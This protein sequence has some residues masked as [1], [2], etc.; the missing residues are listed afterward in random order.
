MNSSNNKQNKN[1]INYINENFLGNIFL[2]QGHLSS[3]IKPKNNEL[4]IISSFLKEEINQIFYEKNKVDIKTF[5]EKNIEY[6]G[7]KIVEHLNVIHPS[8]Y[9]II[10]EAIFSLYFKNLAIN[11]L[12]II[13]ELTNSAFYIALKNEEEKSNFEKSIDLFLKSK[14]RIDLLIE[15]AKFVY[16]KMGY[17]CSNDFTNNESQLEFIACFYILKTLNEKFKNDETKMLLDELMENK[18]A[19]KKILTTIKMVVPNYEIIKQQ[20]KTKYFTHNYFQ[21]LI[22]HFEIDF[23]NENTILELKASNKIFD[24]NWFYQVL[25]YHYCFKKNG[26]NNKYISIYNINNGNYWKLKVEDILDERKLYTYL[27]VNKVI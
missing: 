26:V 19:T 10:S 11:K 18:I 21:S 15:R 13:S 17:S 24:E 2:L 3:L 25:L 6:D 12:N 20:F 27:N 22:S 23:Y 14:K 5:F 8:H 9:G 1:I 4:K 16:K 7:F